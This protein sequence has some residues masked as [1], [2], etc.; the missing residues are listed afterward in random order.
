MARIEAVSCRV[1]GGRIERT[2]FSSEH[3]LIDFDHTEWDVLKTLLAEPGIVVEYSN[4]KEQAWGRT[5]VSYAAVHMAI[6]KLR[7][8]LKQDL[9]DNADGGLIISHRGHRLLS[10]QP[11]ALGSAAQETSTYD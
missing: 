8:K 6:R 10:Q 4:L 7:L 11:L 3:M 1:A 5:T 2:T 9:P